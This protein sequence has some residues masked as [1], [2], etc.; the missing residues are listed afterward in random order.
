MQE[1]KSALVRAGDFFF[2]YR[3]LLFPVVMGIVFFTYAP[4]Y[5]YF[6]SEWAEESKDIVAGLVIMSGLMVRGAVIGFAYIKR[7]GL[8][9]R[10]YAE[11]LVTEGF[12]GVCRNPLYV[13][14]ML[15]YTGVFLMHGNPYVFILGTLIMFG[16]YTCIIA[17]EEHFLRMTFGTAYDEYCRDVP[18]WIPRVS[19]FGEATAGMRFN[20]KRVLL[21]DYSTIANAGITIATLELLEQWHEKPFSLSDTPLGGAVAILLLLGGALFISAMKRKKVF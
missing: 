18:R 5:E 6:S 13:G 20:L 10:V 16:I 14:N 8:N 21:K 9:K 3:N 7:G 1:T 12:F 11:H 15:I 2:K 19:K 4:P 17:A